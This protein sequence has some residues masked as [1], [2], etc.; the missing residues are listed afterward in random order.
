MAIAAG[1]LEATRKHYRAAAKYAPEQLEIVVWTALALAATG[2]LE[3]A[4][5]MFR[6]AFA[7]E[8][9]WIHFVERLPDAG[10]IDSALVKKILA[11]TLP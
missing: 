5:P 2:E 3:N 11:A 7:A 4:V 6:R 8:P 9:N 1:D 10:L